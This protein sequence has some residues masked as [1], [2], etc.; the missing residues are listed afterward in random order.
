MPLEGIGPNKKGITAYPVR[1]L[2]FTS[3]QDN[4]STTERAANGQLE[5]AG[6]NKGALGTRSAGLSNEVIG[7]NDTIM[8]DVPGGTLENGN[9]NF[10]NWRA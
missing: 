9:D 4:A 10:G 8:L 3:M 7:T 6:L 1:D 2:G 5:S